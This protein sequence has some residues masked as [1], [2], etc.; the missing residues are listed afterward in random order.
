MQKH[1]GMRPQ[2][3]IILIKILTFQDDS[4]TLVDISQALDI[5]TAEVSGALERSRIAGLLNQSKRKVNKLALREFLISGLKY[6]FPAQIG[7]AVRGIATSH[8]AS[9]IKEHISEGKEIYVW[10]YSRGTR[11]GSSVLPLYK[12]VPKIV[13]SQPD[14]YEYLVI[15]DTLRIGRV[16]EIEVAISELD[17]KLNVYG[18]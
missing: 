13:G 14:L 17:K 5:S 16:R 4:W 12:T 9:P 1:N 6:V 2:D 18:E 7:P 3:I 8:S 15:I 11:R 10:S